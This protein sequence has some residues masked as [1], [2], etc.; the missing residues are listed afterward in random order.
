MILV[1]NGNVWPNWTSSQDISLQND[2]ECE[3]SRALKVKSN[4]APGLT[5]FDFLLMSNCNNMPIS[6]LL[7]VITTRKFPHLFSSGQNFITATGCTATPIP[8]CFFLNGWFPPW[9]RGK[10]STQNE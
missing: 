2:I 3:L 9:V 10:V 6:H 1:F 5:M 8:E 4:G 7:T